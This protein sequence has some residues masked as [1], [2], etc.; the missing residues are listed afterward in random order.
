MMKFELH[1]APNETGLQH[2]ASPGGP[3]DCDQHW[4]RTI[5]RVA[6]KEC[7]GAIQH[8]RRVAVILGTNLE[9]SRGGKIVEVH[10][11]LDLRLNDVAIHV[12]AE[13]A[14]RREGRCE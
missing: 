4:L 5:L 11:T 3:G 8:D 10:A 13:V 12:V 6:G 9:D 7:R 14:V 1:A 2:G